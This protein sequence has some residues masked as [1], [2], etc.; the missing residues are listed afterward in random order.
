LGL[1]SADGS[2]EVVI[3]QT[4]AL[5]SGHPVSVNIAHKKG[6]SSLVRTTLNHQNPLPEIS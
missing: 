2:L 6:I 5:P 4:I 1:K 3:P